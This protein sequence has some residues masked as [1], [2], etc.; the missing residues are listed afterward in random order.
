MTRM[1]AFIESLGVPTIGPV[2][3]ADRGAET[4][5]H[6]GGDEAVVLKDLGETRQEMQTTAWSGLWLAREH[7]AELPASVA[8]RLERGWWN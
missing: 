4:V 2:R 5:I 7:G 6:F 1:T 3:V 8:G